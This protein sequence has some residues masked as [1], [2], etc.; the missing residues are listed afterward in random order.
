[1]RVVSIGTVI[2]LLNAFAV[3]GQPGEPT[4]FRVVIE[5]MDDTLFAKGWFYQVASRIQR[6]KPELKFDESGRAGNPNNVIEVRISQSPKNREAFLV[7]LS[8]QEVVTAGV[9]D[10]DAAATA[11]GSALS[12]RRATQTSIQQIV[13]C[14]DLHGTPIDQTKFDPDLESCLNEFGKRV[15]REKIHEFAVSC[16]LKATEGAYRIIGT[17]LANPQPTISSPIWLK[18]AE[19]LQKD[20]LLDQKFESADNKIS[21][22]LRRLKI[23]AQDFGKYKQVCTELRRDLAALLTTE[24]TWLEKVSLRQTEPIKEALLFS[25]KLIKEGKGELARILC[26][27]LLQR[28]KANAYP[29]VKRYNLAELYVRR[30][31]VYELNS[32]FR[33]ARADYD[34]ARHA[35]VKSVPASV[36]L[37]RTQ[38]MDSTLKSAKATLD[39]IKPLA[40]NDV[41]FQLAYGDLYYKDN[42]IEMA[43]GC[44]LK[45]WAL[46]TLNEKARLR[47]AEIFFEQA[48]EIEEDYHKAVTYYERAISFDDSNAEYY[49]SKAYAL[50]N[51]DSAGAAVKA[52]QASIERDPSD[53][54]KYFALGYAY[55]SID[56]IDEAIE[57]Y[58]WAIQ[59]EPDLVEALNN[60]SVLYR[61][62]D[63]FKEAIHDANQAIEVDPEYSLAY[64]NRA[65]AL[66]DSGKYE[67]AIASYND[68]I[69]LDTGYMIAYFNRGKC[70]YFIREHRQAESDLR[71]YVTNT[72][73]ENVDSSAYYFLGVSAYRNNNNERAIADLSAYIIWRGDD[74]YYWSFY[75]R[76]NAYRAKAGLD[77]VLQKAAAID[78]EKALTVRQSQ[79]AS[80]E[81]ASVY[82]DLKKYERA[83]VKSR[84]G[85]ASAEAAKLTPYPEFFGNMGWYQYCLRDYAQALESSHEAIRRDPKLLYVRFN[86]A[87]IHL[88]DG[89]PSEARKKYGEA[90]S[91]LRKGNYYESDGETKAK[92]LE[93]LGMVD[94]RELREQT[95][96]NPTMV[97][98]INKII[99]YLESEAAKLK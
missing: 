12:R 91:H 63:Q 30:A 44:Y 33:N 15:T 19:N 50:M 47:L 51:L 83:L 46:D 3:E 60:R 53:A 45:A 35:N 49:Y 76:A 68:A 82:H 32:E 69:G 66:Q 39:G 23:P 11:L 97:A 22:D 79:D 67:S 56:S 26:T 86:I 38:L 24:S 37:A 54:R 43:K 64:Y 61:I 78:Y 71:H 85:I 8:N 81:L 92:L 17:I 87:L 58:T 84:E 48:N 73:A 42:K 5:A 74:Y 65:H 90:I 36:G 13:V 77:T 57:N 29:R 9:L 70:H 18:K 25:D 99:G 52:Y 96:S 2:L 4:T 72:Q 80:F 88:A 62:R 34:S 20:F 1:M 94:L 75:Y 28:G 93:T 59:M 6:S 95:Q 89:H 31:R 55:H 10:I 21:I 7:R 40:E 98:E 16:D 41:D 27:S 14:Y